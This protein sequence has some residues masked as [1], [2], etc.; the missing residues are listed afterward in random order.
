MAK[1]KPKQEKISIEARHKLF[2]A[3]FAIDMNAT[4]AYKKI[5][6]CT[7]KTAEVNGCKLLSNTKVMEMIKSQ[8]NK[9]FENAGIDWQRV[10]RRLVD[11]VDRCMERKPLMVRQGK[12]RVQESELYIDPD[13]WEKQVVWV[14]TFDAAWANSALDKLGKYFKLFT[15]N[16]EHSGKDWAPI[17][18]VDLSTMTKK[19]LW[20]YRQ[21]L[22]QN[23]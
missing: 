9:N 3:E 13:T 2:A 12:A 11:L 16:H 18:F 8:V 22:L 1:P 10:I 21:S 20:D 17:E 23:E 14:R 7:Q 6:N 19:Q 15:I 4:R 5:Y